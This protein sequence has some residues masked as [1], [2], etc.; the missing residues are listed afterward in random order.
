MYSEAS[1]IDG[2]KSWQMFR[3]NRVVFFLESTTKHLLLIAVATDRKQILGSYFWVSDEGKEEQAIEKVSELIILSK[4]FVANKS[5][6]KRLSKML[7][8]YGYEA[9]PEDI[10]RIPLL[11]TKSQDPEKEILDRI[12]I[13]FD[14]IDG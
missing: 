1:A 3:L 14:S 6:I 11:P 12:A 2:L 4:F 13:V 5:S 7:R 10:V 8:K 9:I